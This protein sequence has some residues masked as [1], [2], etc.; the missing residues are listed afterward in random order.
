MRS[1]STTIEEHQTCGPVNVYL[2]R[3]ENSGTASFRI[4]G[5]QAL[6][7][8]KSGDLQVMSHFLLEWAAEMDRE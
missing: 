4:G 3:I 7:G 2:S 1:R 8:F 6:Y 5:G